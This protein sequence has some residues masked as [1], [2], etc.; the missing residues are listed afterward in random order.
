M[1]PGFALTP[2][3]IEQFKKMPPDKQQEA[4]QQLPEDMREQLKKAL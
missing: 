4:M 1:P 2:E 3:L